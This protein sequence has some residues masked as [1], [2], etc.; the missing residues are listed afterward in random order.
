[1]AR[2][3]GSLTKSHRVAVARQRAWN[4]IRVFKV[5]RASD[6]AAT[7]DINEANLQKYLH[8]LQ[9][10]G[11][12]RIE[13]PKQNGKTLGHAIWRLVDNTGPQCPIVRRDGVYDPNQQQIRASRPSLR[14]QDREPSNPLGRSEED[15]ADRADDDGDRLDHRV[16]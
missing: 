6:V 4:A 3:V 7:A 13:R 15:D 11:Y 10:A 1:M 9:Q 2:L 5:F 12:L 8:A 14:S 16:A